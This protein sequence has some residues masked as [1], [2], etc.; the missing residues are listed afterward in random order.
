MHPL[1]GF[2]P[3]LLAWYYLH[4]RDLPWRTTKDPYKI[5]VSEI[6]LQQTR[7]QQGLPYYERFIERFP[8]VHALAE[9]PLDDLLRLWQ[10]LGYYSRARNMQHAAQFIQRECGG[11]F[12]DSFEKLL[13]LK[14]V[15]RYTAAAIASFAFGERVPVVD[16]NVQ[17]VLSRF[18]GISEDVSLPKT[19]KTMEKTAAELMSDA[20]PGNFNQA[21][22]EFGA[23]Y[24]VP[25]RPDCPQCIFKQACF[26]YQHSFVDKLP[27]KGKKTKVRNRYFHYI[28]FTQGTKLAIRQRTGKDI[29]EGLYEFFLIEGEAFFEESQLTSSLRSLGISVSKF[30]T[31]S[32]KYLHILSHQKLHAK[33]YTLSGFEQPASLGMHYVEMEEFDKLGKPVLLL[34]YLKEEEFS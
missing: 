27:V 28:V 16:G 32:D 30:D 18:V 23:T 20:D 5:W 25:Q 4:K 12:P 17:R 34:K 11:S 6:I 7:V 14:G 22:M 21:I 19:Q 1:T 26:A 33:F 9:A 8:T 10:G 31:I 15:G 3:K 24:C 29:W 13:Y 2:A